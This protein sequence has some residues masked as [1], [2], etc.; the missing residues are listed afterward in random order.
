MSG[1]TIKDIARRC[2]VGVSTV[3]RAMNNH[4][5]INPETKE[6]IL[7]EIKKANYVPNNSAQNLKRADAK[8]IAVL[9]KGI[10]NTFFSEL[11]SVLEKC[12][13]E[14]KYTCILQRVDEMEDELDVAL[15]LVR[16][17]KLRGIIFLGGSFSH[18][19]EKLA[20]LSVPYVL[21]T[22]YV[23]AEKQGNCASVAVDDEK[24][25]CKM[26]EYLLDLG[27]RDI[28]ILTARRE[29]ESIGKLRLLGYQQALS[30]HGIPFDESLVCYMDE[31]TD[32]YSFR[33]GY[34]LTRQLLERGRKFTALYAT[35]DTL[36]IGA[37]KALTEAGIRVPEDCSVAGFDGMDIGEYYNPG[38]TTIRQPV[39]KIAEASARLLF[40]MIKKK[41]KPGHEIFEG[42]LL[43]RSSTGEKR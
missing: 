28:A 34:R 11:V 21:S 15:Q 14:K 27:H 20:E 37:C 17:K 8:A 40:D 24:E 18:P 2:K 43:V 41:N 3:S 31:K 33:S 39:E 1:M 29:D 22:I 23:D 26:T 36:A 42:E 19:K 35:S 13:H 32:R 5:D 9:V 6:M 7:R 38:I 30:R 12:A 10:D 4:P 25:S 16:E